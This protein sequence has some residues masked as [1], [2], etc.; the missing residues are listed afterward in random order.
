MDRAVSHGNEPEWLQCFSVLLVPP[1]LLCRRKG[2][3][4]FQIPVL[5]DRVCRAS[6][7]QKI[8][9]NSETQAQND[10]GLSHLWNTRPLMLSP[11]GFME[12][13]GAG[14]T[15]HPQGC[16]LPVVSG[17]AERFPPFS[18][19]MHLVEVWELSLGRI[20]QICPRPTLHPQLF[21]LLSDPCSFPNPTLASVAD[22]RHQQSCDLSLGAVVFNVCVDRMH[23][24]SACPDAGECKQPKQKW[25]TSYSLLL[26]H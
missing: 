25:K 10:T 24:G 14:V 21:L 6:V 7:S 17:V 11:S 8:K 22:G 15:L 4:M 9:V 26:R 19:N 5:L 1:S 12:I 3:K 16:V 18:L 23:F 2:W 20:W 13:V